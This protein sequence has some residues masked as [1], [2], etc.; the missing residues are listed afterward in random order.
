MNVKHSKDVWA[1]KKRPGVV[2]IKV[3]IKVRGLFLQQLLRQIFLSL[4]S[5]EESKIQRA[6]ITCSKSESG[7]ARAFNLC[8]SI[9]HHCLWINALFLS[10]LI[11][12]LPWE[13]LFVC[14][15]TSEDSGKHLYLSQEVPRSNVPV[16]SS[17]TPF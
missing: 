3:G 17:Q 13:F 1:G 15:H 14:F 16:H 11:V 2:V 10:N 7:G 9:S 5:E 4:F 8:I 6:L 12:L